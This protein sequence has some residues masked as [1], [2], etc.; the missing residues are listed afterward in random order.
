MTTQK[1]STGRWIE[2]LVGAMD[3]HLDERTKAALMES[4]GRACARLS[5][6]ASAEKCRGDVDKLVATLEKWV[7]Q[8]NA[9]KDG[10][11][12]HVVYPRCLCHLVAK[13]PERLP[14][15]YCLCSRGWLK[16]MFETVVNHP[17]QVDLLQSVKRGGECCRFTVT[18]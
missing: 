2:N 14:D 5:A 18:L 1:M 15:T 13:G 3:A 8:G 10:D 7:G 4:C 17:V 11:L 12:V 6:I 9:Q 16:E